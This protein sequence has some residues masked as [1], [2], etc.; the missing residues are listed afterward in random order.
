MQ[1]DGKSAQTAMGMRSDFMNQEPYLSLPFSR[2]PKDGLTINTTVYFNGNR[3]QAG[4]YWKIERGSL[5]YDKKERP[6]KV[7]DKRRRM[8]LRFYNEYADGLTPVPS[9]WI[10]SDGIMIKAS[11]DKSREVQYAYD[12]E[13]VG[14]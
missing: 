10:E 6:R 4:T 9:E 8:R 2:P 1:K 11:R 7:L 13:P 14:R 12:I 5:H 3:P